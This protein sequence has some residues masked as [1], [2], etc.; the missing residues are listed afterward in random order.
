MNAVKKQL[1][2]QKSLTGLLAGVVAL[3]GLFSGGLRAEPSFV[4][5]FKFRISPIEFSGIDYYPAYAC[6]VAAHPL[7]Y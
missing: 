2:H 6:A 5:Q 4:E 1:K 3:V 7:C